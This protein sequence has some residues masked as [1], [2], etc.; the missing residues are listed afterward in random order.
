MRA[1]ILAAGQGTRL[2]PI[3]NDQPKALTPLAGSPLI[4][5]QIKTL[6]AGGISEIAIAAGYRASMLKDLGAEVFVNRRYAETN[7]VTSMMAARKYVARND[8]DLLIGYGDIVYSQEN[9]RTVLQTPGDIVVMVDHAWYKLWS[10]RFSDPLV[11]AETLRLGPDGNIIEIGRKPK[12]YE[13]IE[14]QYTGLMRISAAF[15]PL[16]C[17][18]YDTLPLVDSDPM[19][20]TKFLQILID[21]GWQVKP[22]IVQSGWLEVDTVSD[23]DIYERLEVDGSLKPLFDLSES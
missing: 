14:G 19:Y 18:V 5:R 23:L 8:C 12:V 20:M 2:R 1:L 6:R 3:T 22:A 10:V 4:V 17:E 7:M 9:L 16:F 13:E 21:A 15:L 11:D